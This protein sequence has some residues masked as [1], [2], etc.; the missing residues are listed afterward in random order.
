MEDSVEKKVSSIEPELEG[1]ENHGTRT[2]KKYFC[3]W[4]NGGDLSYDASH[5][6]VFFISIIDYEVWVVHVHVAEPFRAPDSGSGVFD[7]QRVG[8]STFHGTCVLE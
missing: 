7:H 2:N 8:L 6:F 3:P 5:F 4:E 1:V